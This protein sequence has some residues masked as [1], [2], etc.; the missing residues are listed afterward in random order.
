MEP[1]TLIACIAAPV[2]AIGVYFIGTYGQ[3]KRDAE[4]RA[5]AARHR[6]M[7][8]VSERGFAD[9]EPANDPYRTALDF[10]AAISATDIDNRVDG[11]GD[12]TDEQKHTIGLIFDGLSPSAVHEPVNVRGLTARMAAGVS[13]VDSMF[14]DNLIDSIAPQNLFAESR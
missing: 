1:L 2:L 14:G 9:T 10:N 8:R 7:K 6:A 13:W 5:A 4:C 11:Y 3:R 12:L